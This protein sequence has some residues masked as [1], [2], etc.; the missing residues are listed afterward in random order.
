M[1]M[2]MRKTTITGTMLTL[3][4]VFIGFGASPAFAKGCDEIVTAPGSIQDAIDGNPKGV[5]C[6]NDSAVFFA[7]TVDFGP[8]DSHITLMAPLQQADLEAPVP[9]R[10]GLRHRQAPLWPRSCPIFR[11]RQNPCPNGDDSRRREQVRTHPNIPAS[12]RSISRKTTT[13]SHGGVNQP[14]HQAAKYSMKC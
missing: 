1:E 2:K 12:D 6:L 11:A 8:E 10:A 5:V 3:L 13:E 9:G 4:M 7:Q 14:K